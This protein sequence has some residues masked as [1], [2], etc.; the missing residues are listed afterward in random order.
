MEK[1]KLSDYPGLI[2]QIEQK[3][4]SGDIVEM[5]RERGKDG[6]PVI[7]LVQIKRT[8]LNPSK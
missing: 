3:I 4:N 6:K 2:E 5:K 8:L 1:L 7:A